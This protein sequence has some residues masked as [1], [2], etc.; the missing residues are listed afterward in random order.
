MKQLSF[1]L[2]LMTMSVFIGQNATAQI[3]F[4]TEYNYSGAY[5][6][7]ANS[8]VKFYI[9]DVAN[10]QCRIFNVDHT[11]WKTINLDVPANHYLYDIKFV[12]EN[13]FTLDNSLALCYIYYNYDE[14][15]QYYTYTTKVVKEDGSELITVPGG[16]YAY[17]FNLDNEGAKFM[18]YAYDYSIYP[19]IVKTLIY[20]LP[21][22]VYSSN[23]GIVKPA[24]ATSAHPNPARDFTMISYEL[25]HGENSGSVVISNVHG[26]IVARYPVEENS[27]SIQ[28][29]T[30][31]LP[32]G[33]YFY[34]TSTGKITSEAGKL[35]V[36]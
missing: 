18:T 21:G 30:A 29:H 34:Q 11:L 28:I 17:A 7:L 25:P 13:L 3:N 31:Q 22:E 14:V 10:S 26:Q 35:V 23:S 19:Y 5:T 20:S 2:F 32:T 16:Q 6:N 27:G 8:G 12:S 1:G 24:I 36:Q 9:M 15:N 33:I 4:E